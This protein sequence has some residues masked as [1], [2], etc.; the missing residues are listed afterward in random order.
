MRDIGRHVG[1]RRH[2]FAREHAAVAHALE[3]TAVAEDHIDH[4]QRRRTAAAYA[5]EPLIGNL[6]GRLEAMAERLG[7]ALPPDSPPRVEETAP[8]SDERSLAVL[9]DF[10]PLDADE[11]RRQFRAIK[12]ENKQRL[13]AL[14]QRRVGVEVD[15]GSLFDVQV[16]RIHEYKRQLLN[17][18]HVVTRYNRIRA[19]PDAPVVPRTVVFAGKAAPGYTMAKAVIKL[20]NNVANVVIFPPFAALRKIWAMVMSCWI[21]SCGS[22]TLSTAI[23]CLLSARLPRKVKSDSR[24]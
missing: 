23:R 5:V 15:V 4:V 17:L 6:E 13:A 20:I 16:K 9:A 3:I 18:L 22:T 14:I 8:L 12:L 1:Q 21:T 2:L 10:V 11:F 7:V 19:N 24:N